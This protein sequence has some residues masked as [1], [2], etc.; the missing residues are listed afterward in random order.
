MEVVKC[1]PS[2]LALDHFDLT[3]IFISIGAPD[4]GRIFYQWAHQWLVSHF[5]DSWRFRPYVAFDKSKGPVC[6]CAYFLDVV[7][8]SQVATDFHAKVLGASNR[9]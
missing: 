2:C 9:F 3:N 5:T 7:V 8:K 1:P 4:R 6:R